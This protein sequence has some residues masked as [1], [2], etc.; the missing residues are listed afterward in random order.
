MAAEALAALATGSLF[1]RI[2]GRVLLVLPFLV[3]AVPALAFSTSPRVAILGVVVYGERP[4]GI[5]RTA[6]VK[7]LVAGF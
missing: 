7:A 3:A 1:D 6:P 2:E 4:S 5:P